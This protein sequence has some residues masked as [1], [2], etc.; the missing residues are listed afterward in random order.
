MVV[1]APSSGLDMQGPAGHQWTGTLQHRVLGVLHRVPGVPHRVLGVLHRVPGVLHR[2]LGVQQRVLGVLHRVPG[3]LHR[4]L[5]TLIPWHGGPRCR[6]TPLGGGG[7]SR[8]NRATCPLGATIQGS[9][10][11]YYH[12]YHAARIGNLNLSSLSGPHA[13][14]GQAGAEPSWVHQPQVKPFQQI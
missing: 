7:M 13:P 12:G 9:L 14:Q 6:N 8:R 4:V 5:G 10:A 11:T 3:V 1:S 2:V